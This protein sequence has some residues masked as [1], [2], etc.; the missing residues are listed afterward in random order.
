[1]AAVAPATA[2]PEKPKEPEIPPDHYRV[3]FVKEGVVLAVH[4][5]TNIL[6]AGEEAGME[7]P[8]SCKAGSCDT[9]SAR[10]EGTPADQSAGSALS[11]EQ[12]KTFVLT[13]IARPKGPI[14]IWSD[15]R[16]K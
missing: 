13:C 10:W 16:P 1:V 7:L 12:Q 8:S 5:N 2:E 15:E 9:C 14:K 6:A 4:K 11:A 3:E